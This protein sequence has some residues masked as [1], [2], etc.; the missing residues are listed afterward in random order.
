MEVKM[1]EFFRDAVDEFKGV[2]MVSAQKQRREGYKRARNSYFIFSPKSRI[3]IYL[4]AGLYL[5]ITIYGLY[6]L[7]RHGE[8]HAQDS[9][10]QIA[11]AV[12]QSVVAAGVCLCLIVSK[13][14]MDDI[15][16]E[17]KQDIPPHVKK[18]EIGAVA[19]I[20]FFVLI[21]MANVSQFMQE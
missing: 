8:E 7:A 10:M 9:V 16:V 3:G 17:R 5:A 19:G 12:A 13:H 15:V 4:L 1:F 6:R 11:R 18:L 21:L 14:M 2:D 20:A